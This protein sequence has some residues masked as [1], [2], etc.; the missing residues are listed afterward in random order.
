[1]YELEYCNN[2][3]VGALHSSGRRLE[4]TIG[5]EFDS[6]L[7]DLDKFI[8]LVDMHTIIESCAKDLVSVSITD[9]DEFWRINKL[10]LNFVNAVYSYKEYVNSYD[11]PLKAITEK[12]YN[13]KKWYRFI[14]DFRNYI[15]HQSIIIKDYRPFDK[16]IFINIDEVIELLGAYKY[17]KDWQKRN[18]QEFQSWLDALKG[19]AVE[20][21]EDHYLSMKNITALVSKEMGDMKDEVLLYAYNKGVKPAL[22]WMLDYCPIINGRYQYAFIIDKKIGPDSVREPNYAFEDFVR[23]MVK[24]LGT[25]ST[26]LSEL[27]TFL[28]NKNYNY[29]YD[30]YCT[31]EDFIESAKNTPNTG[32]H[33]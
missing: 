18:A 27:I 5:Q 30:G 25:D 11:P 8:F 1:M 21:K 24:T 17:P 2:P 7:K 16:D 12:Y 22:E 33:C 31:L 32:T 13:M 10:L 28:Q 20:I 4:Q 19:D 9:F 26:I 15:V 6:K 29:F 14:C 3:E 23:R